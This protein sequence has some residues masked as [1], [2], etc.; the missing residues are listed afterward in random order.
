M[1][2]MTAS[3]LAS[4]E[5]IVKS[6]KKN[7]GSFRKRYGKRAKEVMYA[8]A[9]KMAMKEG[10]M[11]RKK[12][13]VKEEECKHE[14]VSVP[15]SGKGTCRK[16][17]HKKDFLSKKLKP[18]HILHQIANMKKEEVELEEGKDK[19]NTIM[20]KLKPQS[21]K[22]IA[23]KE[24]LYDLVFGKPSMKKEEVEQ[25]DEIS[26]FKRREIAHELRHEDEY[27]RRTGKSTYPGRSA[28]ARE[29]GRAPE[30]KEPHAVHIDGKKWKTFSSHGHATNVGK[31]ISAKDSSKKITI[32]KEEVEHIDEK[33][34][35]PSASLKREV[36]KM[37]HGSKPGHTDSVKKKVWFK[38]V[39]ALKLTPDD[40]IPSRRQL[41]KI[42]RN[43][44]LKKEEVDYVELDMN[45]LGRDAAARMGED[46][47]P[48]TT[49]L[50]DVDTPNFTTVV[51]T[52][53]VVNQPNSKGNVD[54]NV[55][56]AP[57]MTGK[58]FKTIRKK[59]RYGGD[60]LTLG[61]EVDVEGETVSENK[62]SLPAGSTVNPNKK[63]EKPKS[64]LEKR[65]GHL[66]RGESAPLKG[67]PHDLKKVKEEN[68]LEEAMRK[69][70]KL[71]S[72][73]LKSIIKNL[74]AAVAKNKAG[75]D[76]LD[77]SM[78]LKQN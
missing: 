56:T 22:M 31:K 5:N 77:A 12:K 29:M 10:C 72:A 36:I 26:N 4:R 58:P 69:P 59:M 17:G 18:K 6:M 48:H 40:Q 61:E 35:S 25:I 7:I 2:K 13:V 28:A 57:R 67:D 33:Q 47:G 8:T 53:T 62:W 1:P 76:K 66:K 50:S 38:R 37:T 54:Q 27:M 44:A 23:K 16:C 68:E 19:S 14:Y 43:K 73:K 55:K 74:D 30:K 51:D 71:R 15:Y 60:E 24:S 52:S 64:S 65:F 3:D 32:H 70:R 11:Y 39:H 63:Y 9:T 21:K 42:E 20:S 49:K 78:K 41:A 45:N 75:Q 34:L 46:D